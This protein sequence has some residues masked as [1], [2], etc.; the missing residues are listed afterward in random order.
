M[1]DITACS[2]HLILHAMCD[3]FSSF[4]ELSFFSGQGLRGQQIAHQLEKFPQD[5]E[6]EQSSS[7][8]QF[9]SSDVKHPSNRSE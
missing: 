8:I 4:C 6:H 3:P 2:F 9:N 5:I 7:N 1:V